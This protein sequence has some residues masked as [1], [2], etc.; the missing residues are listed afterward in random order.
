MREYRLRFLF[1]TASCNIGISGCASLLRGFL[2]FVAAG[3]H[4]HSNVLLLQNGLLRGNQGRVL[5]PDGLQELVVVD[6][7]VAVF[8]RQQED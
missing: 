3:R 2:V 4:G 7:A 5:V 1:L 8:L 6:Q